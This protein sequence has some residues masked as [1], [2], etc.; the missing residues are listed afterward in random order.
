M[1][2]RST[3]GDFR[4]G[5]TGRPGYRTASKVSPAGYS[6]AETED[7]DEVAPVGRSASRFAD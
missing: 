2:D 5:T 6:A 4:P 3:D 1:L 7:E